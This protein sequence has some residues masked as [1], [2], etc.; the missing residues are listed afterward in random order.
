MPKKAEIAWD[1]QRVGAH[2]QDFQNTD[3]IRL[4]AG[5]CESWLEEV[6]DGPFFYF[7]IAALVLGFEQRESFLTERLSLTLILTNDHG[8]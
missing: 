5:T 6:P 1:G 2:H 3:D 8:R 4:A 7:Y